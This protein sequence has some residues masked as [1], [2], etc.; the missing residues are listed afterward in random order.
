MMTRYTVVW[1]AEAQAQLATIWVD[2]TDRHE[3]TRAADSVDAILAWDAPTI[4]LEI[5]GDFRELSISPL[6]IWFAVSEPDRIVKIVHVER[7]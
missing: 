3:I 1:H 4:G 2:A 7:V 5:E 6:R